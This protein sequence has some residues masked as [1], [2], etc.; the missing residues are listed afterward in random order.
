MP[1]TIAAFAFATIELF[2]DFSPV[3]YKDTGGVWTIGYGHTS[4]VNGGD[5]CT[6]EQALAWYE[7]DSAPLLQVVTYAKLAPLAAA[8]YMSFGYNCGLTALQHVLAGKAA[9]K[10][11]VHDRHGNTLKWLVKRR[12][13]EYALIQASEGFQTGG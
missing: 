4:G 12:N 9:L 10:D 6:R 3:A 2:E 7:T 8:A 13:F 11:F 5:V 1:I